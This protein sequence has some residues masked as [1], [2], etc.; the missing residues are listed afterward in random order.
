MAGSE[1]QTSGRITRRIKGILNER[2]EGKRAREFVKTHHQ[3]EGKTEIRPPFGVSPCHSLPIIM[4]RSCAACSHRQ[5]ITF[6][7]YHP[8]N[9]GFNPLYIVEYT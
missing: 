8:V 4:H 9:Q 5:I 3:G 7:C 1:S 2:S 6:A